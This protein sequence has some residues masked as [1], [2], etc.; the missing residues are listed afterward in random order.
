VLG[1]AA[2]D[3]LAAWE[4]LAETWPLEE[5]GRRL[6]CGECH[7]SVLLVTD[8]HGVRYQYSPTD[9]LALIVLHLRNF[10]PHLDPN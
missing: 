1:R 5:S 7:G 3:Q 10:H 2:V 9:Y 6:E 8:L 4:R